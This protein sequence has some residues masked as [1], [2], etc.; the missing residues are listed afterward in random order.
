MYAASGARDV[1]TKKDFL[2]KL[3]YRVCCFVVFSVAAAA[4]FNGYYDKY[5]LYDT[6][7]NGSTQGTNLFEPMVDGSAERPYVYRQL[8]PMLANCV[9]RLVPEPT[10]DHLFA[11]ES[12]GT[13]FRRYLVSSPIVENRAYFLR[14]LIVYFMTFQFAWISVFAMF[15][16]CKSAGYAPAVAAFSAVVMILLMPYFLTGGGYYYDYPE[17]AFLAILAWMAI[18]FDWWWMIPVVALATWNKESLLLFIPT[19]YP[20]LR[21]RSSRIGALVATGILGLISTAVYFVLRFRF[22]HNLGSTVETHL[23]DQM[24]SIFHPGVAFHSEK[25]YGV[26]SIRTFNPL[27]MALIAWTAWRGWRLLPKAIQRHAQIAAI[28]NIP[29]YF[30]F[31]APLELRDL[32]MLYITFLL[33]LAANL[34][35]WSGDRTWTATPR[36]A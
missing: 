28:I 22:Q 23:M 3:Y 34:S 1:L 25:T 24:I 17:L 13:L 16:L 31:C 32:S 30:L 20:L 6:D 10:K 29:L 2:S 12:H 21:R 35:Q 19:L 4:S 36:S 9:D 15:Q 33:L 14:Y 26:F 18:E 7:P 5:R 11:R 27:V 8:L